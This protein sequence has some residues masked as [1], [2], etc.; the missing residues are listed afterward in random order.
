[1]TTPPTTK[2]VP[3]TRKSVVALGIVSA[4][5][6]GAYVVYGG[7]KH[8]G[9]GTVHFKPLAPK[10]VQDR[11]ARQ[12]SVPQRPSAKQ[13]LFGDL[14]VHTTFSTDAFMRSLPL[15]GGEGAHP[16]ADACDFARYCSAL[17]FFALTDHAEAMTPEHWRESIES[18]RACND[19]AGDA[20]NPDL[21][22]YMGFEWSQVGQTPAEHYGHMN[23]L[24]RN[25]GE[26][27][28]PTRPI[29]ARGLIQNVFGNGAGLPLLTLASIPIR[30][31]SQRQRYLD[32]LTFFRETTSVPPC[33]A[34]VEVHAL[35]TN[36][37][38]FA[39]KPSE[40]FEK[41]AQW[42][43]E[44]LVI[45]HGTTWG[46]YTPPGYTYDKQINPAERNPDKQKLIEVF[47]GHG[48][49]EEYRTFK[50]I[51]YDD[52][53]QA[54]CPAP[55]DSYEP[56]CHRAGE[57]IRSRCGNIPGEECDKRVAE[58]K[59]RYLEAGAAGHLSVPGAEVEDWKDCGQCRD[60]FAPSF[61]YRPG[62]SV[63]YI[64]T[65]GNFDNPEKPNHARF[66]FIASSD[67][68][69]ARPGTG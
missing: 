12:E 6:V 48:N 39:T 57:I 60:C 44:S 54:V 7:G 11:A 32:T 38:E 56:C 8:E 31:F 51:D 3:P 55:T 24:F 26:A 43:L 29:A 52:Q 68:H 45:P 5:L 16:P 23:V 50:D 30:E 61:Q 4:L 66:G 19:A 2:T 37:R 14:H 35:P 25:T 67:N 34:G 65:Q 64:L 49:S 59:K 46:F 62:G 18:I 22:A 47:S 20:N 15:V 28:V 9:P 41:L 17:D 63:Q 69:S 27:D 40:L 21:V 53:G 33:P 42:N 36:C 1:M 13:I 10:L 58:A